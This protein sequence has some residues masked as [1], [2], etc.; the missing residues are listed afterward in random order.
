MD[1]KSERSFIRTTIVLPMKMHDS[2]K[3]MCALTRSS[4]SKFMRV[5]LSDKM[6]ELKEK[7]VG[8]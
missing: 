2:L 5:A 1:K 6:K 3:M 8:K 4:M 7:G